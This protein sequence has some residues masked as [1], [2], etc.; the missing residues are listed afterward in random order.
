[1]H[2]SECVWG[3]AASYACIWFCLIWSTRCRWCKPPR[4]ITTYEVHPARPWWAM[5]LLFGENVHVTYS[6][7]MGGIQY[8]G[9]HRESPKLHSAAAISLLHLL[10]ELLQQLTAAWKSWL[11]GCHM[12]DACKG[13][14]AVQTVKHALGPAVQQQHT[15][16]Y[17]TSPNTSNTIVSLC[18]CHSCIPMY[19]GHRLLPAVYGHD[20]QAVD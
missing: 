4:G 1:M 12:H 19:A 17:C 11:A 8:L 9:T 7:H 10:Q 15:P 16:T 6:P 3:C 5:P 13:S 20:C 14:C 18:V 2:A